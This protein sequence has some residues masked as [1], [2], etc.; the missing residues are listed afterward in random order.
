LRSSGINC[1]ACSQTPSFTVQCRWKTGRSSSA[2]ELKRRRDWHSGPGRGYL[3]RRF[4]AEVVATAPISVPAQVTAL[5]LRMLSPLGHIRVNR[6]PSCCLSGFDIGYTPT[7]A[8]LSACL[9]NL[10]FCPPHSTAAI[11]CLSHASQTTHNVSSLVVLILS[12]P[13]LLSRQ[14][15]PL[16]YPG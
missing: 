14:V 7:P 4:G 5:L 2:L 15:L 3:E 6:V 10:H 8:K 9:Q 11:H 12:I 16:P 1:L 13:L